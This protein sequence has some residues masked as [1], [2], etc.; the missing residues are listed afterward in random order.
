[1]LLLW[2]QAFRT[3]RSGSSPPPTS[4]GSTPPTA[5]Q[6]TIVNGDL[7]TAVL[8][9]AALWAFRQRLSFGRHLAWLVAIVGTAIL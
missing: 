6:R 3:S 2:F 1:M 9:V 5:A 4:L 8:A 7:A